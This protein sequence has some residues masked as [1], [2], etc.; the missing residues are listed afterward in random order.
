VKHYEKI[1]NM[2]LE[3]LAEAIQCPITFADAKPRCNLIDMYALPRT[4]TE[5]KMS[6]LQNVEEEDEEEETL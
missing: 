3:E 1:Q 5:C 6:W 2:S 4:C